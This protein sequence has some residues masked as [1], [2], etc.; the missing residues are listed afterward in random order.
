MQAKKVV[1]QPEVM[2]MPISAS[3]ARLFSAAVPCWWL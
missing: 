2:E 3:A 1:A